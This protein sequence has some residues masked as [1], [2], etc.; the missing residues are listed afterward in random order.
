MSLPPEATFEEVKV[1]IRKA[2]RNPNVGRTEQV[3]LKEGP[4]AFRLATL[5]EIIK[6]DSGDV[7]HH[8]LKIDSIDRTKKGWFYRPEKSVSLEGQEPDEIDR[9]FCFMKAHL[10]GKLH[11]IGDLHILNSTEYEKL[12]KLID[13]VPNL[14]S[15]D[16]VELIKLIIPRIKES[17]AYLPDF[18]E[19]FSQADAD[20]VGHLA[21]AARVVQHTRA[22]DALKS[23]VEAGEPSEQVYQEL[24][25]G[26]P[27][28]FGSEYSEL[29]DRRKWTRD[30][31]VDFMLRRTSDNFLEIIEIKTPFRDPLFIHDKSHDSYYPSSRLSPVIGQ[32][33]RY[34]SEIERTR[35]QILSKDKY[36]T[37]KI[38][39][40]IIVGRDGE[41]QHQSALRTLNGHLHRIEV[42]TF[43]QLLRIAARVLAVFEGNDAAR[44]DT[45]PTAQPF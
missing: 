44:G 3:V 11:S 21:T 12:G 35:D 24:L 25:S 15:P 20:T 23:L 43:D 9:L 14:A 36:D 39:A 31:N 6:P 28:M 29:L 34:I 41:E 5:M 18:V 40:R 2:T 26:N 1:R 45:P 42:L 16:M 32:V 22:Y 38:R 8:V 10:E 30:D 33:M 19:A 37:L 13:L 17:A 4:R 27:W 7:H